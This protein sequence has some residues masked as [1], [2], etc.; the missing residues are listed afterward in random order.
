M[1]DIDFLPNEYRERHARRQS[2][3]WQ[4]FVTVAILGLVVATG[5]V[6]H[7][8]RR[9]VENALAKIRPSYDAAIFEQQELA[10]A[11]SR[12]KM[13]EA[14]ADLYVYLRHPWPRTQLLHALITPLPDGITLQQIQIAREQGT[15]RT[16]SGTPAPVS[17]AEEQ[18]RLKQLE[19]EQRDLLKLRKEHDSS[20]MTVILSGTAR[21][22]AAL[23]HYMADLDATDIFDKADLDCFNAI[24]NSK[25]GAVLQ[26][27]AVLTVQPGWGQPG[28]PS[29]SVLAS[30][31]AK[32]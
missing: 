2:Q 24:D 16:P 32:Q 23:H 18:E 26:F 4:I 12:L 28:G 13:V 22:P 7:Y 30:G 17:A 9:S 14:K 1:R 11:K 3:P 27:R 31:T 6:Q 5:T 10:K 8:H 20:Q 25:V 21:D 15:N 19:P 29:D